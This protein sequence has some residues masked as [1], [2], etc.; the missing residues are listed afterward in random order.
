MCIYIYIVYIYTYIYICIQ[1]RRRRRRHAHAL[2]GP[3]PQALR[4]GRLQ[5]G[6]AGPLRHHDVQVPHVHRLR[7]RVLHQAV[8]GDQQ[9]N[10]NIKV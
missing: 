9:M 5:E 8:P 3:G 1:G 7:A 6:R 10:N 4:A 2:H